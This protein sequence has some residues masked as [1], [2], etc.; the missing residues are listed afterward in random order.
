MKIDRPDLHRNYW[1]NLNDDPKL[2]GINLHPVH[3][4]ENPFFGNTVKLSKNLRPLVYSSHHQAV[5]DLGSDLEITALSNDGKVVEGLVHKRY[6]NVFAVQFHPEVPALYENR[7]EVRF[8]P[9]DKP[10]TLHRMLNCQ[11]RKFH[12]KYW[13]H[14]SDVI[15][16]NAE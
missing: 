8:S 11:S 2:M 16:R 3:F 10:E 4:T 9:E 7:A 5:K 6:P 12:K 1:Q 15:D 13:G 14:I